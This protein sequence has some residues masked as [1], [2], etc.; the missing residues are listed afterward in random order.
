MSQQK[1][2]HFSKKNSTK[3]EQVV[4]SKNKFPTIHFVIN[5]NKMER[6][7][8]DFIPPVID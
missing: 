1:Y 4:V 2:T 8:Q 7:F 5:N 3:R 6:I